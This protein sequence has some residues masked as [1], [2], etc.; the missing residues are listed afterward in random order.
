MDKGEESGEKRSNYEGIR[1]RRAR[2][3]ASERGS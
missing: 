1:W 3:R 2:D